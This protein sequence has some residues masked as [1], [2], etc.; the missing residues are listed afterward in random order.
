MAVR[1]E[2]IKQETNR[3]CAIESECRYAMESRRAIRVFFFM[4]SND[5][6]DIAIGELRELQNRPPALGNVPRIPR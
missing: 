5:D 1:E 4:H 6:T 2:R 3:R